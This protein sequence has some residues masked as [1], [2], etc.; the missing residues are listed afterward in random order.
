MEKPRLFP[1]IEL[2][3]DEKLLRVHAEAVAGYNEYEAALLLTSQELG[4]RAIL[5]GDVMS[6]YDASVDLDSTP[7][8]PDAPQLWTTN[9]DWG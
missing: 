4:R 9:Q 2:L 1:L 7:N 8:P 6:Y 3:D 5:I